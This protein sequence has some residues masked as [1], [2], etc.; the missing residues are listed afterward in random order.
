MSFSSERR[1]FERELDT[2]YA[3]YPADVS[4]IEREI[5]ERSDLHPDWSVYRRK[6][7]GYGIIAARCPVKVFRHFPFAFELATGRARN[8]LGSGGVGAWMKSLPFGRRLSDQGATWW[9][10]MADLGVS[11]GWPVLDDN[12]HAPGIDNLLKHGCEGLVARASERLERGPTEIDREFLLAGIEGNRARIRVA[13]RLADEAERMLAQETDPEVRSRLTRMAAAARHVPARPPRTFFEALNT[14]L[15]AREVTQELEGN[16]ISILG[17]LD[18]ILAPYYEADL[19]AGRITQEEARDLLR[20]FLAFHDARFGMRA[21]R[22]HVGTNTTVM[23]GGCDA[24]GVPVYNAITTMIADTYLELRIVDPKLNARVSS[25]HPQAYLELLGRLAASGCNSLSVFNDDVVVEANVR[26]GKAV[27][28]C[29]LYAG[30]GCQENV[31][32]NTEVNS[33]ATMYLNLAQVL[34]MGF[35]PER[36][37]LLSER[38]GVLL[39]PYRGAADL[40]AFYRI[41][42]ANLA[43]VND[44]HIARRNL[45]EAQGL[46]F[47]PCPLHSTT[48]ED[49]IERAR[50][51]MAGGARYNHG[52]VSFTGIATVIDSLLALR[53]VVFEE[54][55]LSLGRLAEV[56]DADFR[57]EESLRQYL[58]HRVPKFGRDDA[59]IGSFAARVFA[60][61]AAVTDGRH[62]SRGG[63]YEASLFSFTTYQWLGTA[64]G[65]TPDGRRAGTRLSQGMSPTGLATG[66]DGTAGAVLQALEPLDLARYPVVAVLDLKL[67]VGRTPFPPAPVAAVV[68]R[69]VQ[70]GGSVLQTNTICQEELL[71]ARAHPDRH[72]DLVV[73]VSGYS[74][75]FVSLSPDTQD[76]IVERTLASV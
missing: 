10:T 17:H 64:T 35:H 43:A 75:Y 16:G 40:E 54:R 71:D 31:L 27:E 6:A 44:A 12:H 21:A 3:A 14:V 5:L 33:R 20:F 57:G 50:D 45:S 56:L 22:G 38:D 51:M 26:M 76:D 24:A 36:W 69:F 37:S 15:F 73:R 13:E 68:R 8:D 25:I 41:Y 66:R 28:D 32:E 39:R 74:A 49:C 1:D 47:N 72:P 61:H 48:I 59:E 11:T 19:E 55:R 23:I 18:R 2:Y 65:A 60:D 67:P 53:R 9:R 42:L 46:R 29:R 4:D 63:A 7:M 70:A 52:S 30:G 58:L 34:L 62:N